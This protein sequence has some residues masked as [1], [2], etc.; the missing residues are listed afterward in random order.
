MKFFNFFIKI[1]SKLCDIF[2]KIFIFKNKKKFCKTNNRILLFADCQ[3][4]IGD[5][6][7]IINLLFYINKNIKKYNVKFDVIV[8]SKFKNLLSKY[9]WNE[10]IHI[11]YKNMSFG[12]HYNL[13]EHKKN[14]ITTFFKFFAF[15]FRY[16]KFKKLTLN[17]HYSYCFSIFPY[18]TI[19]TQSIISMT[20][21]DQI[22][23]IKWNNFHLID[24]FSQYPIKNLAAKIIEDYRNKIEF[25]DIRENEYKNKNITQITYIIINKFLNLKY[26]DWSKIETDEMLKI[27]DSNKVKKTEFKIGYLISRIEV[28]TIRMDYIVSLFNILNNLL[29]NISIEIYFFGTKDENEFLEIVKNSINFPYV[30]YIG[31]TD[32][33]E[34]LFKYVNEMDLI[35]TIDSSIL[36]VANTLGKEI[37]LLLNNNSWVYK[38]LNNFYLSWNKNRVT[39]IIMDKC[40]FYNDSHKNKSLYKIHQFLYVDLNEM[41]KFAKII[42][43]K[44][45]SLS[46]NVK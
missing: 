8:S 27:V 46:K 13:H 25:V 32:K 6:T 20:D 38:E 15:I 34:N 36:H 5:A 40:Y 43:Q 4:A 29:N 16:N 23:F 21:I 10:R 42:K 7:E 30:S 14:I 1:C 19:D 12:T 41:N 22:I 17:H 2:L 26:I 45:I 39:K 44:I 3:N 11:I 31:K 35:V 18:I 9:N 24:Y 33:I 28:K 37:I